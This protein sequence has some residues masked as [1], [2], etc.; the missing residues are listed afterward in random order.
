M[1]SEIEKTTTLTENRSKKFKQN[2]PQMN[3]PATLKGVQNKLGFLTRTAPKAFKKMDEIEKNIREQL[4]PSVTG[5]QH[6]T[7]EDRSLFALPLKMG[8]LDLLSNREFSRKYEWS[9]AIC[10]PLENSDPK[11]AETEQ[12]LI[13]RN[14]KT[15]RQNITLS[16]KAKITE[17][18][19]AEKKT[20]NKSSVTERSIEL[21]KQATLRKCNFSL[22]KSEF[23]D[24][25]HLRY[26][27]EPPYT[28][29][30]YPYGQQFTLTHSLHCPKEGYTHLRHKEIRDIYTI[31]LDEESHDV[32]L[33]PKLQSLEG[34]NFHNETTTTEDDAR[35]DIKANGLWG[36]RFSRTFLDIKI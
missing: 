15:E 19:S 3:T 17:N 10:D 30:T 36:G 26:E 28:P 18:G 20:D 7:D 13:N 1:E 27:L 34:E 8:G 5:K 23:K 29:H 6:I 14:M 11:K 2:I 22:N 31:L 24:G 35:L 21:A 25:L 33:E 32:E 4:L 16:E 9:R 12:S